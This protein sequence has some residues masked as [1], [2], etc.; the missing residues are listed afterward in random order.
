MGLEIGSI[1]ANRYEILSFVAEG[2]M[3]LLF[4]VKDLKLQGSIRALKLLK[5]IH[6]FDSQQQ[7]AEMRL[8][9]LLNHNGLPKIYD[10]IQD[11]ELQQAAI[12]ME[13]IEGNNIESIVQQYGACT[14]E[15]LTQ[16]GLQLI[17]AI[18]YLHNQRPPIIHRDI[19]PS[20]IM[21]DDIDQ[22]KLI[23]FG[24][25]KQYF[26][27][28]KKQTVAFGSPGFAA[29]EQMNGERTDHRS[30]IYSFGALLYYLCTNGKLVMY[31]Q[32]DGVES[33]VKR[34]LKHI[35]PALRHIIMI[36]LQ[37]DRNRRY[38]CAEEVKEALVHILE[39][40]TLY[41]TGFKR[42]VIRTKAHYQVGV[43]SLHSKAGATML[44]TLMG[45]LLSMHSSV[46]LIEYPSQL[47]S[48]EA[49]PFLSANKQAE[50]ATSGYN[51]RHY[52]VVQN[53]RMHTYYY[54]SRACYEAENS[55]AEFNGI[56]KDHAM[57]TIKLIDFSSQWELEGVSQLLADCDE[58]ILVCDPTIVLCNKQ[59]LYRNQQLIRFLEAQDMKVHC[60]YNKD[61]SFIGRRQWLSLLSNKFQSHIIPIIE[62]RDIY[63]MM[64]N[65]KWLRVKQRGMSKVIKQLMTLTNDVN[66]RSKLSR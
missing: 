30:D 43:I 49:I 32:L 15:E 42:F 26:N 55:I 20:N 51:L 5:N 18:V 66:Q 6:Q 59:Q 48:I 3:G 50:C 9:T 27:S 23:D 34:E 44:A 56:L 8:L 29:P 19:K 37:K 57:D 33:L 45:Q 25:S 39:K 58:L 17:E 24:I 1:Y 7:S 4:K 60:M 52:N 10:Y 14:Q 21:L 40:N 35:L 22:L 38:Q 41:H 12:I 63:A 46:H 31:D 36:C 64:W 62:I 61:C 47:A 28:D 53:G 11:S 2:G 65:E 54:E 16:I 13:W